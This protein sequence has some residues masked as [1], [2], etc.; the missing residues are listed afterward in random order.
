MNY[1]VGG[2]NTVYWVWLQ[3]QLGYASR[4]LH[5]V[6]EQPGDARFI[7]ERTEDDLWAMG[8]FTPKA[9]ERLGGK[10]LDEANRIIDKCA[11]LGYH[12]YTPDMK[13]Y[14]KRLLGIIDPPAVL[15]VRGQL[16]DI[17]EEPCLAVVGTRKASAY[18]AAM[19]QDIGQRLTEAGC[20]IVSGAARGID[21]AAHQGA[22]MCRGGRTVAVLGCGLDYPYNMEGAG[23][24]DVI[25]AKG[26]VISEYPPGYPPSTHSFP[27]RNRI[28]S[29]ISIGVIVVE[30]GAI[31]GSINTAYSALH[32]SRDVFAVDP[33][34][35]PYNCEGINRLLSEGAQSVSCPMDVLK[36]YARDFA[37]N[38]NI[39]KTCSENFMRGITRS[40]FKGRLSDVYSRFKMY[41]M[42]DGERASKPDE[43]PDPDGYDGPVPD[44]SGTGGGHKNS[45]VR[46][47]QGTGLEYEYESADRLIDRLLGNYI[48]S[49]RVPA[50]GGFPD[51]AVY[52]DEEDEEYEA[53]EAGRDEMPEE[54]GTVRP[55]RAGHENIMRDQPDADYMTAPGSRGETP[56][57][58]DDAFGL[59]VGEDLPEDAKTLYGFITSE[60]RTIDELSALSGIPAPKLPSLLTELE[61]YGIVAARFG[62]RYSRR[63]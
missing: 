2:E 48:P 40:S 30:A 45:G 4:F 62:K 63:E 56:E 55:D 43:L 12:I 15:Y 10:S 6:A 14:P 19:A 42:A 54:D 27:I 50:P 20:L 26:A 58:P 8:G 44:I 39:D 23:L 37:Y 38:L 13:L 28:I 31:S 17:D 16:P 36:N 25:A 29:G 5:A 32:Q 33:T 49:W 9:V 34:I 18:G 24:R 11:R 61:L 59:S 60:P 51:D 7:Y 3:Q 1:A 53:K 46:T 35:V 52:E 57:E 47:E 41:D 21:T 22:L